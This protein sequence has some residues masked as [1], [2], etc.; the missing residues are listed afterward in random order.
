MVCHL[1][2]PCSDFLKGAMALY[3]PDLLEVRWE[4]Y[5]KILW[6]GLRDGFTRNP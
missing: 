3:I 2:G 4:K 6:C 5:Y 1:C